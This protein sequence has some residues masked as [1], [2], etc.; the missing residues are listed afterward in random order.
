MKLLWKILL[1]GFFIVV[2][3]SPA[4]AEMALTARHNLI[5]IQADGAGSILTFSIV[6]SNAGSSTLSH[7]TLVAKDPLIIEDS[8]A[9]T[10]VIGTVPIGESVAMDWTVNSAL[11]TE[12]L[13]VGM[14][15]PFNIQVEATDDA[16]NTASFQ[17]ESKGGAL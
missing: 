9:S 2:A 7:A 4:Y 1:W 11:S 10:K 8:A 17:L 3:A 12:Q 13:S 16:G 14:D 5:S 15:I 6:V